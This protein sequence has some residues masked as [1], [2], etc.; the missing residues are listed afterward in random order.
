MIK[1]KNSAKNKKITCPHTDRDHFAKGL[2]KSCYLKVGRTKK[3]SAC[4]HDHLY[5][6]GLCQKCYM[7]KYRLH[8]KKSSLV[9]EQSHESSDISSNGTLSSQIKHETDN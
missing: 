9:E 6:K 3:P 7:V 5:A 4:S 1:K 8:Q 2:C